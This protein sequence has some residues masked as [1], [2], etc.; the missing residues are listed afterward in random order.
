MTGLSRTIKN[1][2]ADGDGVRNTLNDL[3]LLYRAGVS[4]FGINDTLDEFLAGRCVDVSEF[5]GN[6]A[7]YPGLGFGFGGATVQFGEN[8]DNYV[9]WRFRVGFDWT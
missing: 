3:I 8:S 5:Q 7:N 2:D 9:D 6:C 1:P 4:S